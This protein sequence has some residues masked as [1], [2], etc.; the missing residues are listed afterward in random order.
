MVFCA[1]CR[2]WP[3]AIAAA[4]TVW[5]S[6]KPRLARPGL[7]R[8]KI[9]MIASISRKAS[10]KATSGDTIIGIATFSRTTAQSAVT[11]AATAAPT[12]PPISACDDEEGS[13]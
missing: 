13:P 6:R 1:S 10:P 9:H 11:P 7:I 4:D 2:P 3:S 12:R 8:R 5:A